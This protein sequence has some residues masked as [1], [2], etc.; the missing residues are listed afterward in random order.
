MN[1]D[2]K[3]EITAPVG[4]WESLHAAIKA[5]S[6]SV[7]F[8]VSKLNM[9]ARA[10]KPFKIADISQITDLCK[11][12]N[13]QS[14]LT[15][16][17]LVYDHEIEELNSICKKARES[18]IDA[19]I[20]TDIASIQTAQ[21]Y[22][23]PI[24]ISTQANITNIQ[25]FRF[26]AQFADVVVLARELTIDQ[27]RYLTEEI[28]TQ[29]ILG[30]SGNLVKIELFVHGALCVA[31]A[32]KCGM[33]LSTQNHSANRG[34]CFQPCRRRYRVTDIET[35]QELEIDNQYVMSPKDISTIG[36]VDLLIESGA[37]IFKI[38]GRGR[39]PDYV[40]HT[41]KVYRD[42]VDAY[43]N[44]KYTEDHIEQWRA[45][46]LKVY[47]RGFWENGY[48]LGHPLGEWSGAQ[49]SQA[50]NQRVFL[51][52]ARNYFQKSRI[53]E[54]KLQHQDLNVGEIIMI[55]G[56]TTGYIEQKVTSI[57]VDESSVEKAKKGNI[58]TI[59]V[60]DK[61][62]PNDKLFVIRSRFSHQ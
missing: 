13:I 49:G 14:Y 62:R 46:L 61:V 22:D 10:A 28:K 31:I 43:F 58:I 34:D 26:Y 18:G 32:G 36:M 6:D 21:S 12:H 42:A 38:E 3:I 30:P 39:T 41:I 52:I 60:D 29:N 51:G 33:S 45:K 59:P 1:Q 48:Y 47:N 4:S 37:G 54:F 44:G 20:A 50:R 53:A 7:Y 9:R 11:S 40:Y 17:T 25:S 35:D 56:P 27:I 15:L 19:V 8:G 23:L 57:F 2:R 5:G 55:T 16:N 24:H